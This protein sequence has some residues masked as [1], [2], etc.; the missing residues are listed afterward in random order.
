MIGGGHFVVCLEAVK[1]VSGGASGQ[2]DVLRDLGRARLTLARE[3]LQDRLAAIRCLT[4][5][6]LGALDTFV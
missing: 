1:P 4:A 6:L 5:A 3:E 2:S